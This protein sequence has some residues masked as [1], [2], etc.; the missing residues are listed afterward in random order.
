MA[1]R[2]YIIHTY[3]GFE[4]K[5]KQSLLQRAQ[6]MGKAEKENARGELASFYVEF[7]RILLYA[8]GSMEAWRLQHLTNLAELPDYEEGY[9]FSGGRIRGKRLRVG[10]D[11]CAA[12]IVEPRHRG[13]FTVGLTTPGLHAAANAL[14]A[15]C[16]YRAAGRCSHTWPEPR[17]WYIS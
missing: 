11:G 5:V 6:A 15:R 10:T 3:S 16:P 12:F 17:A 9:G 8:S 7:G 4:S 14:A 13:S 2:W 1:K